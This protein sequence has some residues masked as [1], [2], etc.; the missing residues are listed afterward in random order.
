V[1]LQVPRLPVREPPRGLRAAERGC[2][3]EVRGTVP[4]LLERTL[5]RDVSGNLRGE[6]LLGRLQRLLKG[7]AQLRRIKIFS[8]FW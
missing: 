2:R 6:D 1:A 3:E 8:L 5:E 4:R 7:L